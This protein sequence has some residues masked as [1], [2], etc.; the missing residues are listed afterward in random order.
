MRQVIV[1]SAVLIGV[2]LV[3]A[4]ATGAG[5]FIT[6]AGSAASGYARTLQGR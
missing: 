6:A 2:Y 4:N 3:V 1:L 5:K